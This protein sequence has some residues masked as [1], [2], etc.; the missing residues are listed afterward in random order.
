[1]DT[2]TLYNTALNH[3]SGTKIQAVDEGGNADVCNEFVLLATNQALE[4]WDWT[5]AR[6]RRTL[7]YRTV[8]NPDFPAVPGA[9]ATIP[10]TYGDW[11]YVYDLPNDFLSMREVV[12][13]AADEFETRMITINSDS[14]EL[15]IVY[16][17]SLRVIENFPDPFS[18]ALSYLLAYFIG[19][20]VSGDDLQRDDG[21]LNK[22]GI[23]LELAKKHDSRRQKMSVRGEYTL[24]EE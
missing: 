23:F 14:A 1:M 19:A 21:I 9:P 22:Y 16:T 24:V 4:P 5:F 3:V 6:E 13:H 20:R 15:V 8:P 17:S 18:M 7:T 12:D 10:E 2:V 11:D